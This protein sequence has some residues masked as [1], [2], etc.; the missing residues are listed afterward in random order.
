MAKKWQF[1]PNSIYQP[2]FETLEARV[3]PNSEVCIFYRLME[4]LD[5]SPWERNYK[6]KNMGRPAI[7]PRIIASA[8]I[9][10]FIKGIVSSRDLEYECKYNLEFMWLTRDTRLDHSTIANF[11]SKHEQQI[12][13]IFDNVVGK[14]AEQE[15]ILLESVA[16]DG[17]VIRAHNARD[18]TVTAKQL[19]RAK[20][21]LK[22]RI[23]EGL[24]VNEE[25]DD[26]Q[27]EKGELCQ[28]IQMLGSK[29]EKYKRKLQEKKAAISRTVHD[30]QLKKYEQLEQTLQT[31]HQERKEGG[32][33]TKK[34]AQAPQTDPESRVLH[35]KKDGCAPGYVA[36]ATS[37]A[38]LGF[39]VDARVSSSKA[40]WES[41][42]AA[43][44]KM[45]EILGRYPKKALGDK[46]YKDIVTLTFLM[47]KGVMPVVPVKSL[48][49]IEGDIAYRKDPG[50][51]VAKELWDKLPR[52][53]VGTDKRRKRI[54]RQA[55]QF[56][57]REDCFY[58]PMGEKLVKRG[59]C[60][61]YQR[62]GKVLN[63]FEYFSP[64]EQCVRCPLK[65]QCLS[66]D[67]KR[68][69][70]SRVEGS[71][72]WNEVANHMRFEGGDNEYKKRSHFGETFWGN[73][74]SRLKFYQFTLRGLKKVNTEMR[75]LG[76]TYNINKL[77]LLLKR[78]K[79][80][81]ESFLEIWCE[82]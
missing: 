37:D 4:G 47:E 13:N 62:R 65:H 54:S 31:I 30:R 67:N 19:A 74:K 38:H 16:T 12:S 8:I 79:I 75:W 5:W 72:V 7:P 28:I 18:K 33:Y 10:G 63:R 6:K 59:T 29:E 73:I 46:L 43:I 80:E 57:A 55:F 64:P 50:K 14:L 15:L 48:G 53:V 20:E 11:K 17:T 78:E 61:R 2:R 49:A 3:D 45:Y 56:D 42:Q 24:Q 34:P 76:I 81:S 52:E 44:S 25:K 68:R 51:P 39:V 82:S 40:E 66:K 70:L 77:V 35:L 26:E 9:W 32:N 71:E 22:Q 36:V 41:Q 21:K 1:N 27:R 23:S 69:K 58:C 60:K